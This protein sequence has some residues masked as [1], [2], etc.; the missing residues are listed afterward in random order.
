MAAGRD[1]PDPL[2]RPPGWWVWM[3]RGGLFR[4]REAGR[5]PS[6]GPSNRE[7]EIGSVERC[8]PPR[9]E[10]DPGGIPAAGAGVDQTALPKSP[11]Q[12]LPELL[13][14]PADLSVGEVP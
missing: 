5:D 3:R 14:L 7:G 13:D 6:P 1:A 10:K 11:A 2:G 4:L 9:E 12:Q 8:G